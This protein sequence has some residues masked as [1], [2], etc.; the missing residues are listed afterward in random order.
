MR[1]RTAAEIGRSNRNRGAQAER[2]LAKFL[3]AWWPRAERAVVTGWKTSDRA[4]EDCG[5]IRGTPGL[6]WQCKAVA[7]M[8]D[9]GIEAALVDTETQAVAAGADYGI[10]VH[11]RPG[12][13]DPA[14]WW[15]YLPIG[16]LGQLATRDL[17][18]PLRRSSV[19][20]PVRL[21]LQH[22]V[23]LLLR[24]GYGTP[25]YAESA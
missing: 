4:S 10:L 9:A 13:S 5:D 21:Q 12:K 1:T 20:I 2:D 17:G 3:R 24:A 22:L 18:S 6:V 25:T 16:D 11:R 7:D 14:R 23:P 8:S 15:A 19:V